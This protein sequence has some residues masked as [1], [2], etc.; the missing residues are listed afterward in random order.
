MTERISEDSEVL[1]ENRTI[2]MLKH[3][4]ENPNSLSLNGKLK[5]R[6]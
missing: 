1:L 2:V 6:P 3:H 5:A 4:Y